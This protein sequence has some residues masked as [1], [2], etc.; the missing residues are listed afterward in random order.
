MARKPYAKRIAQGAS[1]GA[2]T[3]GA[4]GFKMGGPIPGLVGA[5]SGG[6]SGA[7]MAR[8][9]DDE[10]R[11][12]ARMRRLNQGVLQDE[13]SAIMANFMDPVAGTA[14]EQ[15]VRQRALSSPSVSTGAQARQGVMGQ[16]AAREDI[17]EAAREGRLA[18]M[19]LGERRRQQGQRLQE[20]FLRD[21]Q[22]RDREFNQ[23]ML[24]EGLELAGERGE[25]A[26]E[27]A[28]LGGMERALLPG[29]VMGAAGR[30][31]R[32]LG[33]PS[34]RSVVGTN[35]VSAGGTAGAADAL[36]RE[37]AGP[38]PLPGVPGLPAEHTPLQIR[39]RNRRDFVANMEALNLQALDD[40]AGFAD[41]AGIPDPGL[42]GR[43]LASRGVDDGF[44]VESVTPDATVTSRPL[45]PNEQGMLGTGEYRSLPEADP[46]VLRELAVAGLSEELATD[47]D[48]LDLRDKF[49]GLPAT[50]R[51]SMME[52]YGKMNEDQRSSLTG[53]Y[54]QFIKMTVEL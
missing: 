3:G 7:F 1:T 28:G 42:A 11:L 21:D 39:N 25:V 26:G 30:V 45:T 12:R 51:E 5:L 43:M 54:W 34:R 29:G 19:D 32:R 36:A 20:G 50:T 47:I 17:A 24:D 15:L 16:R 27:Q 49:P 2:M 22:R 37:V 31:A 18:V 23:T 6:L 4:A 10:E 35:A 14:N 41:T 38:P 8:P 53:D 52:G 13:E 46:A 44:R 40:G 9:G 33:D 48:Y